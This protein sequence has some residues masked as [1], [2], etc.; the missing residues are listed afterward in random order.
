MQISTGY[1][2]FVLFAFESFHPKHLPHLPPV[3]VSPPPRECPS[4]IRSH[5]TS[6]GVLHSHIIHNSFPNQMK[7]TLIKLRTQS[8]TKSNQGIPHGKPIRNPEGVQDP[9]YRP[10]G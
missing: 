4:A 8:E 2:F 1:Q 7:G 9:N 10:V 5:P 6:K 3:F